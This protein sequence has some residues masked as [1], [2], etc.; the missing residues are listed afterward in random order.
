MERKRAQVIMLPTTQDSMLFIHDGTLQSCYDDG[1]AV[2]NDID[3]KCQHLYIVTDDEIKEGDWFMFYGEPRQA[4]DLIA[5][6]VNQGKIIA[7][8]D[9]E[10]MV[11]GSTPD[12]AKEWKKVFEL[13]SPSQSF[14]EKYCKVGG[15]DEVDVEYEE[16]YGASNFPL[17]IYSLK[18]ESDNTITIHPIKDSWT[19]EEVID[20][21]KAYRRFVWVEGITERDLNQWIKENL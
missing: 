8:T 4:K 15:I 9:S 21:L 7:T 3:W 14:I 5:E 2:A 6:P 11:Q 10:L 20:V 12:S 1:A 18:V 19:R 13:P 17:G 16:L